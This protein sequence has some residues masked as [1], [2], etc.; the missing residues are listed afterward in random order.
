M[1]SQKL[2]TILIPKSKM[3]MKKAEKWI[4]D[5]NFIFKKIDITSNYYRFRQFRPKKNAIYHSI[6][7]PN[8]VIFV[9]SN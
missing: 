9:Y 8:G 7:L 6:T 2:Q 5:H 3:S 1:R 4:L